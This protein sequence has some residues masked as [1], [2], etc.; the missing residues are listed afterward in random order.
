MWWR[1]ALCWEALMWPKEEKQEFFILLPLS[2]HIFFLL[3]VPLSSSSPINFLPPDLFLLQTLWIGAAPGFCYYSKFSPL[4]S[5][6]GVGTEDVHQ[7]WSGVVVGPSELKTILLRT[8][9]PGPHIYPPS[10][11]FKHYVKQPNL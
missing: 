7:M 2:P 9:L 11:Y 10:H 6:Q 4:L 3:P 5:C 8:Q 1:R